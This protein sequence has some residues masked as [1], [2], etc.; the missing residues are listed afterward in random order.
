MFILYAMLY[1]YDLMF[2]LHATYS[3]VQ[4]I[5]KF[6]GNSSLEVATEWIV[7][8]ENDYNIDEMPLV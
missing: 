7:E 4:T 3:L 5:V 1:T 8:H 2:N 6:S